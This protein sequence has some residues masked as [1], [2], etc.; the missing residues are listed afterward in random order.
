MPLDVEL[1]ELEQK[2]QALER[3]LADEMSHPLADSLRVAELKRRKLMV[4]DQMTRLQSA[5]KETV[6]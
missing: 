3:E 5:E 4:K 2:H 1:S 6:H